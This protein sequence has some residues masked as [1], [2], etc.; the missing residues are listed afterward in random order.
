MFGNDALFTEFEKERAPCDTI[1]LHERQ[2]LSTI[3]E[4]RS[5]PKGIG[6]PSSSESEDESDW[7]G[8]DAGESHVENQ[9]ETNKKA[10]IAQKLFVTPQDDAVEKIQ[11]LKTENILPVR[12]EF[13]QL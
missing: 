9:N 3:T 10:T 6:D 12:N 4:E 5:G 13:S 2:G 1:I 11:K 8:S 7:G